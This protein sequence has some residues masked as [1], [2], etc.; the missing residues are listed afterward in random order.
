MGRPAFLVK[1][2]NI[3]EQNVHEKCELIGTRAEVEMNNE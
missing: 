3:G 1:A 2:L